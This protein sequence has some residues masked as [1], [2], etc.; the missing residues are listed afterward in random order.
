MVCAGAAGPEPLQ[1]CK[2]GLGCI[3]TGAVPTVSR[4]P[5]LAGYERHFRLRA[6]QK[7]STSLP[8]T[9]TVCPEPARVSHEGERGGRGFQCE[10]GLIPGHGAACDAPAHRP[11]AC[12]L[13]VVDEL[14]AYWTL[15][16]SEDTL[17]A[18]EDALIVRPTLARPGHAS[19]AHML[20]RQSPGCPKA[21]R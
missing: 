18:L 3:H 17:E 8:G 14:F 6:W 21:V 5:F 4:S 20:V 15:E 1:V 16:E 2:Q 7:L 9:G 11:C 10:L 13:Q 19:L 12:G